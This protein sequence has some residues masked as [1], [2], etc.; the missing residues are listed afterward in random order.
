[1]QGNRQALGGER[2]PRPGRPRR[3]IVLRGGEAVID[4]GSCGVKQSDYVRAE[5]AKGLEQ[6]RLD[7][8]SLV[9]C[10]CIVSGTG[11]RRNVAHTRGRAERTIARLTALYAAEH[12][13]SDGR[14]GVSKGDEG[15]MRPNFG[16]VR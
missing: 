6:K 12:L 15:T 5:S 11:G 3:R 16:R 2:H 8:H 14:K 4:R 10:K 13:L 1:M 9:H 7:L